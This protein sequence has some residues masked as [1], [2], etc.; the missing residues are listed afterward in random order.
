L[1]RS[2]NVLLTGGCLDDCLTDTDASEEMQRM[3]IEAI[4]VAKQQD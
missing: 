1:L 3:M 2:G 4:G